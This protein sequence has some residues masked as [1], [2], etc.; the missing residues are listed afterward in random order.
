[1]S[2]KIVAIGG[3]QNGRLKPDGTRFPYETMPMDKEI[4]RLTEKSIL[5]FY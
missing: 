5:I 3:G 1:M 4:I 2:R